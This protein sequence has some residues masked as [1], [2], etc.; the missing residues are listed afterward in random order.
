MI[1]F[2]YIYRVTKVLDMA[3]NN[4]ELK[5]IAKGPIRLKGQNHLRNYF[6]RMWKKYIKNPWDCFQN[7]KFLIQKHLLGHLQRKEFP[8]Y[9]SSNVT[10][11]T[12]VSPNNNFLGDFLIPLRDLIQLSLNQNSCVTRT[13][14][15]RTM[16]SAV[17]ID[18]RERVK[19]LLSQTIFHKQLAP[20][21][22]CSLYVGN[23]YVKK[24]PIMQ[25][26][27]S[28]QYNLDRLQC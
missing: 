17:T 2:F 12:K 18:W 1:Y 22:Y 4:S 23:Q 19:R 27:D 6:R 11:W 13:I 26:G 8:V 9:M 24:T 10:L 15:L 14:I 28:S 16:Y 5:N 3:M 25:E 21:G 7:C 20:I